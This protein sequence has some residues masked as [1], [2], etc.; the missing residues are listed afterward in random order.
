[1]LI[2]LF[3]EKVPDRKLHFISIVF[4][5]GIWI[6]KDVSFNLQKEGEKKEEQ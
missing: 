4:L 2:L 5:I 3:S 6:L 1:M